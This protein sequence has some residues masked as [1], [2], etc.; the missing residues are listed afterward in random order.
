MCARFKKELVIHQIIII[1]IIIINNLCRIQ[2]TRFSAPCGSQHCHRCC[3]HQ[4]ERSGHRVHCHHVH[5]CIWASIH[6][7]GQSS[8]M[9]G[10]RIVLPTPLRARHA[11]LS[12]RILRC[13]RLCGVETTAI[14]LR[15]VYATSAL[16]AWRGYSRRRSVGYAMRMLLEDFMT[17]GDVPRTDHLVVAVR[18][19]EELMLSEL[20]SRIANPL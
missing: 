14:R 20:Q 3:A 1:I 5:V 10:D 9:T 16:H 2:C 13:M 6:A 12:L 17:S 15:Y 7:V 19:L 8:I 18:A 4:S 11:N